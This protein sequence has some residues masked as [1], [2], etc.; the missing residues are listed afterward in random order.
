MLNLSFIFDDAIH[1]L[2]EYSDCLAV[3]PLPAAVYMMQVDVINH[4]RYALEH[5]LTLTLN[6]SYVQNSSLGTPYQ[7]G[8]Y[9][10]NEDFAMLSFA[11][12]NLLRYPSRLIDET[13]CVL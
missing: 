8:A 10:T 2:K 4:Y 7:K 12:H 3:V 1:A 9:F 6:E 13:E 11:V 5:Y